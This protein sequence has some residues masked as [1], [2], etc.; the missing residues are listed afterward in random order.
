LKG[1]HVDVPEEILPTPHHLIAPLVHREAR[2]LHELNV[3]KVQAVRFMLYPHQQQNSKL[4]NL[5]HASVDVN[6]VAS[7]IKLSDAHDGD[8]DSPFLHTNTIVSRPS[9]HTTNSFPK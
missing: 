6:L 5:H 9:I 2:R 3:E 1:R 7:L 8:R 4:L